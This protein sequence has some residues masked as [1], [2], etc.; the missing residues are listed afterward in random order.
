VAR[1][2]SGHVVG[3]D[4]DARKNERTGEAFDAFA[5]AI[6]PDD[7]ARL[8][9]VEDF[10]G[11]AQQAALPD[12]PAL[13]ETE[14]EA[15]ISVAATLRERWHITLQPPWQTL[16]QYVDVIRLP[17]WHLF[18]S[19]QANYVMLWDLIIALVVLSALCA[20]FR[21][22]GAELTVFGLVSC[23]H[24]RAG[25]RAAQRRRP[26]SRRATSRRESLAGSRQN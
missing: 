26:A 9:R 23:P 3:F 17:R 10:A 19:P 22:L 8:G 16:R 12:S 14:I 15:E 11:R 2:R 20:G 18:H 6:E 25:K 24:G 7:F 1:D 4:A 5:A 13:F 21:R